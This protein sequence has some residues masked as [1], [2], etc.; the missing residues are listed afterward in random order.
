M[1]FSSFFLHLSKFQ[2]IEHKQQKNSQVPP[3]THKTSATLTA[4]ICADLR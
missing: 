4:L 1:F 3:F 2:N